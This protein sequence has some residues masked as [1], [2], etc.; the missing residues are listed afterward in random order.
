VRRRPLVLLR[1]GVSEQTEPAGNSSLP[2]EQKKQLKHQIFLHKFKFVGTDMAG[3]DRN[4][5]Y[6]DGY[7]IDS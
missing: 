6:F 5:V 2:A 1:S 3:K 4:T 7:I